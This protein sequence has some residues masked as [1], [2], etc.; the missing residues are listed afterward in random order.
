MLA[1]RHGLAQRL[2][3]IDTVVIPQLQTAGLIDLFCI[4]ESAKPG[5]VCVG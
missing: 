4:G 2:A 5:L 3:R 1:L